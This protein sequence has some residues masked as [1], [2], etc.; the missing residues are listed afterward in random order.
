MFHVL[1]ESFGYFWPLRSKSP[2]M[3]TTTTSSTMLPGGVQEVYWE[4]WQIIIQPPGSSMF[5]PGSHLQDIWAQGCAVHKPLGTLH[6]STSFSIEV[7]SCWTKSSGIEQC[8]T[9]AEVVTP[10]TSSCIWRSRTPA[11]A[12]TETWLLKFSHIKSSSTV[13][14]QQE[15][16]QQ[17]QDQHVNTFV[18]S[19]WGEEF[20]TKRGVAL[21]SQTDD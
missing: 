18:P 2:R 7:A 14:Q 6:A 19:D 21:I 10:P 12:S 9:W 16:Q 8:K 15:E 13:H 20:W 17:E 4:S 5:I 1:L 11:M 3:H